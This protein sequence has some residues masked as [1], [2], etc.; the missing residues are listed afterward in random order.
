MSMAGIDHD[1]L[2]VFGIKIAEGRNFSRDFT[3]DD[4]KVLVNESFIKKVG[5]ND[6]FNKK[7]NDYA[8][9]GVIED[10]HFDTLHKIIEPV[11]I[12]LDNDFFGRAIF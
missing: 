2:D 7:V 1:F 5:W 3:G 6:P 8:V 11:A 10:F 9:I 12:F 4:K